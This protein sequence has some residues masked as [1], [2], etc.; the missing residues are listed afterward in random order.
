MNSPRSSSRSDDATWMAWSAHRVGVVN[1][2]ASVSTSRPTGTSA[3]FATPTVSLM[4]MKVALRHRLL[5]HGEPDRRADRGHDPEAQDDLRLR[6]AEDLEVMV[7]GGHQEDALAEGLEGEDLDEHAQRFDDE[8]AAED[9]EQ[10]L[11]LRH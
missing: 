9:Q 1:A 6:P 3:S 2:P 5:V 4:Y 7:D 10:L 8:D 11:G